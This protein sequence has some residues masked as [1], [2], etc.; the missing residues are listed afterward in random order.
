[1]KHTAISLFLLL[2]A[3]KGFSQFD[4]NSY[5][6]SKQ[7]LDVS[8]YDRDS[9]ATALVLYE[10][11]N[12]YVDDR[13][14]DLKT[15][16]KR[17]VKILN[18]EGF[19][20]SV[21]TVPLYNNT[22]RAE[23]F[24]NL[25]ATTYNLED[26]VTKSDKLKL[27]DVYE[28]TYNKNY[29]LVKFTLPNIKVGSVI[30]YS[31]T[32]ESPFMY[33]FNGWEFQDDIPKIYSEYNT[34]IPA[35]YDYSIKLVGSLK[36]F[37]QNRKIKYGCLNVG[38]GG[39]ADCTVSKY[40]MK[41]IPAFKVEEFMTT[42][43]NYLAKIDYELKTFQGFDG[44]K[45]HYT[46]TWKSV[47][48]E[49]RIDGD[50]GRQLGKL[51]IAKNLLPEI[52]MDTSDSL[53]QAQ[54][55]YNYVQDQFTWNKKFDIFSDVSIKDLISEKS[56][57]VSEIN[58]LLHNL[59]KESGFEV[60]SILLSTRNNGLPTLIYPVISDFNYLIVQVIINGKPYFLDATD[61]YLSFGQVAFR[62]LNQYGRLLDFKKGS[63]WE[64]ITPQKKSSVQYRCELELDKTGLISGKTVIKKLG[65]HAMSNKK[66]HY[67]NPTSYFN[68]YSDAYPDIQFSNQNVLSYPKDSFE[69][70]EEF[71]IEKE[72]EIIGDK[73]YIDPFLFKFFTKN[74]FTLQERTYPIDFGYKDTYLYNFKIKIDD[75]YE[76]IEIPKTLEKQLPENKGQLTLQIKKEANTVSM[77][78]KI[79]FNE[80]IY[81]SHYYAVLKAFMADVVKLQTKSLIVL[82]K[83]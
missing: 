61:D 36:L 5:A 81:P 64:T 2:F 57:N 55:I 77:Y 49:L 21:I 68:R 35:N 40:I 66:E 34:S 31:Y 75:S 39:S 4:L 63:Y 18:K 78:F 22:K 9:T 71:S 60:K 65:Y 46:K 28:E 26:G 82:K 70:K 10:Y 23:R 73:L 50:L 33:K 58:I 16:V 27:S 3:L 15:E 17:K 41:N 25:V 1:M 42:K 30:T 44:N 20:K 72:T 76:V 59:L 56:G 67:E 80:A 48:K 53:K 83:K 32:I 12:S 38:N 69:F 7:D 24:N 13:T 54:A 74:P 62:A 47:D 52:K 43:E 51:S 37:H 79:K 6:V 8:S 19:D 29:K 14:F 45:S 11:G